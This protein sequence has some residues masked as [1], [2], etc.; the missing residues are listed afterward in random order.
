MSDATQPNAAQSMRE[1]IA[2]VRALVEQGASGPLFGGSFLLAAGLIYSAASFAAWWVITHEPSKIVPASA[3]IWGG[4]LTSHMAI[5][6]IL[7]IRLRSVRGAVVNRQNRA[8]AWTWNAVGLAIMTCLASFFLSA[9]LAHKPEVFSGYP[10][11]IL[12]LYG[13]GWMVT[14]ATSKARWTWAVALLS[15]LFALLSGAFAGSVHL[16]LLF[17]LALLVLLAAPGAILIRQARS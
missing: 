10:T 17:A 6:T 14:A 11:V 8:F 13:V 12:A 3:W 1:D 4:A 15:F 7:G 9:W 5:G 2:F 16:P